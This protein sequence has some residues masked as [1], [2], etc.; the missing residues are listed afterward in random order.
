MYV[1]LLHAADSPR[2][3]LIDRDKCAHDLT[4]LNLSIFA[5]RYG[6]KQL[7]QNIMTVLVAM[8]LHEGCIPGK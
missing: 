7:R 4:F 2:L 5:G 6:T 1:A 8:D 3:A